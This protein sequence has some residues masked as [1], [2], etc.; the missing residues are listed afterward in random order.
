MGVESAHVEISNVVTEFAKLSS[1]RILTPEFA[2]S[3]ARIHAEDH[4]VQNRRQ[5]SIALLVLPGLDFASSDTVD[6]DLDGMSPNHSRVA[7]MRS[8]ARCSFQ[9]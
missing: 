9:T 6:V 2:A 5:C 4:D 1:E 8:V 3:G 7:P